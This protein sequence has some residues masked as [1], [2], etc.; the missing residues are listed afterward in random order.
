MPREEL[1]GFC[2]SSSGRSISI[3][4]KPPPKTKTEIYQSN[5]PVISD[6]Q[7]DTWFGLARPH[8]LHARTLFLLPRWLL[9]LLLPFKPLSQV[10]SQTNRLMGG[11]RRKGQQERVASKLFATQTSH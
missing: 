3:M 2:A 4:A 7:G 8:Y 5:G 6:V 10:E 1:T 9:L 11:Q